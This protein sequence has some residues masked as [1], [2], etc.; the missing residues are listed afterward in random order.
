MQIFSTDKYSHLTSNNSTQNTKFQSPAKNLQANQKLHHQ[1]ASQQIE[2][3]MD[4]QQMRLRNSSGQQ[5][6]NN[7]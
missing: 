2:N 3:M 4:L 5:N 7:Q 6:N 1:S